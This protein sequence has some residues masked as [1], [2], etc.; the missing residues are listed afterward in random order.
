[1]MHCRR[2]ILPR[3]SM[4]ATHQ[5]GGHS[6]PDHTAAVLFDH[7]CRLGLEGSVEARGLTRKSRG[8]WPASAPRCRAKKPRPGGGGCARP[9][10]RLGQVSGFDLRPASNIDFAGHAFNALRTS[11]RPSAVR[12]SV[13]VIPDNLK[14]LASLTFIDCSTV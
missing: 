8:L 14:K 13:K 11:L 5:S 12:W 2:T 10:F 9:G 1:L 4:W 3:V 7:V 6:K